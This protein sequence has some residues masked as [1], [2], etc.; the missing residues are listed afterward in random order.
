MPFDFFDGVE[1][2]L[3]LLSLDLGFSS[4]KFPSDEKRKSKKSKYRGEIWSTAFTVVA[5]LLLYIIFKDPLPKENLVQPIIV[6]SIIGLV[7]SFS[8]FFTL[9]H[10][11][12]YYFKNI[13]KFLFFSC[14]LVML[15][16]AIVLYIYFKSNL[17]SL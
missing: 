4:S 3:D 12:L 2:V 15:M 14:S 9:Y 6:C 8:V 17:F 13:F 10:L 5:S 7:I 16:I 11:G 1:A